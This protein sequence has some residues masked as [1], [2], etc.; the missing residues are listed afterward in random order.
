MGVVDASCYA[1]AE[2]RVTLREIKRRVFSPWATACCKPSLN[3]SPQPWD[4]L[5]RRSPYSIYHTSGCLAQ[6][7]E[8]CWL[9]ERLAFLS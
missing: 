1:E 5:G 7:A 2:A 4:C 8:E 6:G 9:E 3:G